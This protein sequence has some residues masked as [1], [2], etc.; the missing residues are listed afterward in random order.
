MDL[1]DCFFHISCLT[2]RIK[3]FYVVFLLVVHLLLYLCLLSIYVHV[4]IYQILY[5]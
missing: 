2:S 1:L 3:L 5:H 4:Q